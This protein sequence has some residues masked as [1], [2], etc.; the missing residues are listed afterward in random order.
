[1]TTSVKIHRLYQQT[2][3]PPGFRVFVDRL[4]PRGV[5]REDFKFDLWC[6]DLAPS[7]DLR[8]WFGHKVQNWP[9]FSE[10]YRDELRTPE[11]RRRIQSVL[12]QADGSNIVLLYGAK[13]PNH[14]HAIILAQEFNALL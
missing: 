4:W 10:R 3:V 7:P 5:S 14:N 1:M 11:Q 6:K 9:D 13:D 12:H 8:R 2:D